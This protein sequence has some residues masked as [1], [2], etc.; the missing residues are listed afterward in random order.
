MPLLNKIWFS[1]DLH[2]SHDRDFIW[3]DRG[4]SSVDEMNETIIKNF[5]NLIDDDDE[6]FLL[7][8]IIMGDT[9]TSIEY[10]K[11]LN[12]KIHIVRGNHDSVKKLSYYRD[13]E[14]VISISEGEYFD[15][16]KYHF[17]LSHY[18]TICS[19]FDVGEPLRKRMVSLCGHIHTKDCFSDINKGLIFHVEVDTNDCKPW[20][21]DDIIQMIK[22]KANGK[23]YF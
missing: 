14:N 17:Y 16:H 9:A 22:E 4:F 8:D 21:I 13:C 6:L 2:F 19:N 15:Y 12:G 1:S 18:P 7:G 3:K 5:N 10:L 20:N 11:R 23:V